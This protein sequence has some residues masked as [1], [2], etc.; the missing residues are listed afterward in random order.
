VTVSDTVE[1]KPGCI[2]LCNKNLTTSGVVKVTYYDSRVDTI[3]LMSGQYVA[4]ARIKLVWS[5][6][7][8]AGIATD[9]SALYG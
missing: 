3:P 7:T 5:T 8:T 9:I 2:G 1:L 6:G 4:A